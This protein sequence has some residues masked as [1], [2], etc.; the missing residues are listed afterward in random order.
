MLARQADG[1]NGRGAGE[2][3]RLG[4]EEAQ[5]GGHLARD[6]EAECGKPHQHGEGES[7]AESVEDSWLT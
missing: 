4:H 2:Q 5:Q 7:A 3:D 6:D 1:E